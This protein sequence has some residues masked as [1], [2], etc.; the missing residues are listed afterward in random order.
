MPLPAPSTPGDAAI[1]RRCEP[2]TISLALPLGR[3]SKEPMTSALL[4]WQNR[5]RTR[6]SLTF[7]VA[8]PTRSARG[9]PVREAPRTPPLAARQRCAVDG[10]GTP[11]IDR[12]TKNPALSCSLPG[13]CHGSPGLAAEVQLPTRLHAHAVCARHGAPGYSPC[14]DGPHVV[15]RLLQSRGS[16]STPADQ[17][18]SNTYVTA[19]RLWLVDSTP[20]G[21]IG[22]AF[23][24][25]G[26]CAPCGRAFG[27]HLD[28][29]SPW[30]I[31]PNLIGPSTRVA[32]PCPAQGGYSAWDAHAVIGL[33]R[34]ESPAQRGK[35]VTPEGR[36]APDL[37]KESDTRPH[38][39]C[40]PPTS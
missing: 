36:L 13:G 12:S 32:I 27:T 22:R 21:T 15:S 37:A 10:P 24:R 6:S 39:G 31:Y 3:S 5:S 2:A 34:T 7:P 40:L 38:P 20:K 19:N 25:S 23:S 26:A 1:G 33:F 17:P 8:L 30:W 16:V 11:S 29:R 18:N 14:A 4:V 28:D 9:G 35:R